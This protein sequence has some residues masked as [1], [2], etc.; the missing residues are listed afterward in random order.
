MLSSIHRS[1]AAIN[2]FASYSKHCQK[3]RIP[4]GSHL[5]ED[6]REIQV[7]P[8]SRG[9][10]ESGSDAPTS[11]W[12]VLG[13]DCLLRDFESQISILVTEHG[14][15]TPEYEG[16]GHDLAS[17][18]SGPSPPAAKV[19]GHRPRALDSLAPHHGRRLTRPHDNLALTG[20]T[21]PPCPDW[22]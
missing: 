15:A 16:G 3:S 4:N 12:P 18:T 22:T 8:A 10:E 14:A 7:D 19:K 17:V 11:A 21:A 6:H 20:P 5:I 9:P 2:A 1:S 13:D